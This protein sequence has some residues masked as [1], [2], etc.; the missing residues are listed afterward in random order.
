[1]SGS[2]VASP[3]V[4]A[5]AGERPAPAWRRGIEW[6]AALALAAVWFG[7]GLWKLSDLTV[8][9]LKMTQALV[10]RSVAFL[11]ALFFGAAETF[12][13]VLLLVPRWRRWGALLS[14]GLLAAFMGYIGIHYGAL[15]GADC[16]C[17]PWLKRAIGPMFFVED[18]ALML[19]AVA[20][21][22]WTK[23]SSGWRRARLVLAAILVFAGGMHAW[24]YTRDR[25]SVV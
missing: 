7:A 11:A 10:P 3:S 8:T 12:A 16:T 4:A 5:E 14:F 2:F 24:N 18:A 19:V 13:G 15:R 1:M 20:A 17:F 25:K 6:T 23:P 22:I 21:G 9:E